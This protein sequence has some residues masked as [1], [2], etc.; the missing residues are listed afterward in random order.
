[1]SDINAAMARTKS[2]EEWVA[3]S[4]EE[5]VAIDHILTKKRHDLGRP[6]ACP[7]FIPAETRWAAS[8]TTFDLGG[9]VPTFKQQAGRNLR[10]SGV[11][12]ISPAG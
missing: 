2:G 5:W 7:T 11:V 9:P 6:I 12:H 8:G 4:G 10:H 1:M 3:I